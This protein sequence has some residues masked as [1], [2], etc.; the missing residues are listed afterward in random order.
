MKT[1]TGMVIPD[2]ISK[3]IDSKKARPLIQDG[4]TTQGTT[5]SGTTIFVEGENEARRRRALQYFLKVYN[6]DFSTNE[7]KKNGNLVYRLTS[8]IVKRGFASA[9][10]AIPNQKEIKKY[11]IVGRKI[12][13]LSF[14]DQSSKME[15]VI[16]HELVHTRKYANNKFGNISHN[17][18]KIDFETVGRISKEGLKQDINTKTPWTGTYYNVNNATHKKTHYGNPSLVKLKLPFEQKVKIAAE[19]KIRD[20]KLLTGS[21]NTNIVGKVAST[22]AEK[23]FPKSFF[24]IKYVL[25]KKKK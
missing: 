17:E 20:R 22:R 5:K 9:S 6:N 23:L 18:R 2:T 12:F 19:G 10:Y 8:K 15:S 25:D 13:I 11:H 7:Q 24:N 21:I 3:K 1:Y 4:G 16:T 14:T